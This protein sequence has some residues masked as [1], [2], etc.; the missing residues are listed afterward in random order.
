MTTVLPNSIS[1]IEEAKAFLKALYDNGESFHPDDD[2]ADI[3]MD[4]TGTPLF[5]PSEATLVSERMA[6][7]WEQ[8][9]KAGQCPSG[10]ILRLD[11]EYG[12][13]YIRNKVTQQ[14]RSADGWTDLME[15]A[16]TFSKGEADGFLKKRA[17]VGPL[18]KQFIPLE[19]GQTKEV[20]TIEFFGWLSSREMA[21]GKTAIWTGSDIYETCEV[22]GPYWAAEEIGTQLIAAQQYVDKVI[23]EKGYLISVTAQICTYNID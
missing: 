18:Y 11:P 12:D 6:E 9:N 21:Q 16:I 2:P 3:I 8:F 7:V 15:E 5:S 1:T 23:G 19:E 17:N 13:Y 22:D 20:K 10:F 4:R 14:Y